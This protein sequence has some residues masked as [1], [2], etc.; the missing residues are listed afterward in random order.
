MQINPLNL[1]LFSF[2]HHD[3]T[4]Y[5]DFP[6]T[7][8]H[9][10]LKII[11]APVSKDES[12]ILHVIKNIISETLH[13]SGDGKVAITLTGGF[14]S[15]VVLAALLHF[16]VKPICVTY[17]DERNRDIQISRKIAEHF[18]L[19][20]YNV[21]AKTPTAEWY[22]HWIN[23]TIEIDG[24]NAHLHRAHRTAA[25]A[26]LL[27]KEKIEVLFTGH[28]GGENIRGLSY[29]DYFASP[30]FENVNEGK[31]SMKEAVN[32]EM[33]RY[34]L[35]PEKI[36]INEIYDCIES[37]PWM[38]ENKRNNKFFFVNELVGNIHHRQDLRIYNHFVPK[39]VPLFLIDEYIEALCATKH[40]F[41][42]KENLRFV[43]LQHPKLYCYLISRLF[44]DLM[45]FE[46]SNG[47][48]P[49]DYTKGIIYYTAKRIYQKKVQ[50][51][52][53]YPSFSYGTWYA[54]WIKNRVE[55]IDEKIWEIYDEQAYK[56][57]LNSISLQ[58][59]EGFWHRFSNPLFFDLILKSNAC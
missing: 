42:R 28:L 38:S 33:K 52:K 27:E 30:L 18:G 26:E 31:L 53:N 9:E 23:K 40:H 32:K 45:Q 37:L 2:F 20:H 4:G 48:A 44:P 22:E 12:N 10:W 8:S 6:I 49:V 54:D 39:V 25:I 24:G 36:D 7:K 14:D 59:N 3:V 13:L 57:T 55:A 34:F 11:Q 47:Y 15:R 46:L 29:N 51:I 17:G 21:A 16:G 50:K 5:I 56:S 58:Q 41:L 35:R 19:K 1:A 43:A